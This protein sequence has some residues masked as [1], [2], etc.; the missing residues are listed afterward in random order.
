MATDSRLNVLSTAQ[1]QDSSIRSRL[2]SVGDVDGK[3]D[4]TGMLQASTNIDSASTKLSEA[5][6]NLNT[7]A[8]RMGMTRA[9][10]LVDGLTSRAPRSESGRD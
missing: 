1:A 6:D 4:K 2:L 8:R 9:E 5:A 3:I 10:R 7:A